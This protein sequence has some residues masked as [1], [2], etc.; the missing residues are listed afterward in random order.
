AA[1]TQGHARGVTSGGGAPIQ[2]ARWRSVSTPPPRT[3]GRRRS[4]PPSFAARDL[5]WRLGLGSGRP[6]CGRAVVFRIGGQPQRRNPGA[7]LASPYRLV[8]SGRLPAA[9]AHVLDSSPVASGQLSASLNAARRA[10]ALRV[11]IRRVTALPML[12]TAS[13][14]AFVAT[15]DADRSK[16]FYR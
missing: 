16:H 1:A 3:P 14:I 8:R 7:R 15:A 10:R 9:P 5:P 2:A 11:T 13:I 12:N 4:A 6:S